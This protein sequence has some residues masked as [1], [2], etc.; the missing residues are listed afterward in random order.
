MWEANGRKVMIGASI[1]Q[2]RPISQVL[3][4]FLAIGPILASW[5]DSASPRVGGQGNENSRSLAPSLT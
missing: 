2:I 3:R 4:E 1:K 5:A